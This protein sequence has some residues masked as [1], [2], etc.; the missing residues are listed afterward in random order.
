MKPLSLAQNAARMLFF[1]HLTRP[2]IFP[3]GKKNIRVSRSAHP[4]AAAYIFNIY[5]IGA[6]PPSPALYIPQTSRSALPVRGSLSKLLL[7]RTRSTQYTRARS[8]RTHIYMYMHK[9]AYVNAYSAAMAV[10]IPGGALRR[11]RGGRRITRATDGIRFSIYRRRLPRGQRDGDTRPPDIYS[12]HARYARLSSDAACS[13]RHRTYTYIYTYMH[14]TR[15]VQP[16]E[17]IFSSPCT[18]VCVYI[19]IYIYIYIS[20]ER[21]AFCA[22]CFRTCIYICI[23]KERPTNRR[24][25]ERLLYEGARECEDLA[26]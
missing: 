26:K 25:R 16:R 23:C 2:R 7:P 24:L 19:Y 9:R 5:T 4:E 22:L 17:Y 6:A 15:S 20:C 12:R 1:R 21:L 13:T 8:R 3:N 14:I 18:R 10:I 11:W